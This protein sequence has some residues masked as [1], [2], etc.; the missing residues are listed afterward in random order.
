LESI[1]KTHY[2]Y[3]I[4][5]KHHINVMNVHYLYQKTVI[6]KTKIYI[7]KTTPNTILMQ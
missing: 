4:I 2:F 7:H 3:S 5:T 6:N 1:E